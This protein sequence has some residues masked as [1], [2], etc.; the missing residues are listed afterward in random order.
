MK[1]PHHMPQKPRL[2]CR[3]SIV[4][5]IPFEFCVSDQYSCIVA[6]FAV[7]S[8]WQ[9]GEDFR[10]TVLEFVQEADVCV[11]VASLLQAHQICPTR[12]RRICFDNLVKTVSYICRRKARYHD[13]SKCT[14][15][16]K[17]WMF[18]WQSMIQQKGHIVPSILKGSCVCRSVVVDSTA[19]WSSQGQCSGLTAVG[20][21]QNSVKERYYHPHALTS[22]AATEHLCQAE[23]W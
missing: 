21:E 14:W 9:P 10:I 15:L 7:L 23:N 20:W 11:W 18:P 22:P 19:A 2:Q 8:D 4:I 5:H 6:V 1:C 17:L 3:Y 13:N 16:V 12:L